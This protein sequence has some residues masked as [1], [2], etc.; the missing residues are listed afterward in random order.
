[1]ILYSTLSSDDPSDGSTSD[2]SA[3][4]DEGSVESVPS[5]TSPGQSSEA[6]SDSSAAPTASSSTAAPTPSSIFLPSLPSFIS[7]PSS[8]LSIPPGLIG[9]LTCNSF[10]SCAQKLYDAWK[11]N[12]K[13]IATNY[14]T[15]AA[16]NTLF[17]YPFTN[18]NGTWTDFVFTDGNPNIYAASCCAGTSPKRIEFRFLAGQTGYKVQTVI[19]P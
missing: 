15:S 12:S 6:P 3:V 4:V 18:A 9:A 7:P 17:A 16:V 8:F 1:M 11:S 5:G 13:T 10:Q 2:T 14:A 19:V